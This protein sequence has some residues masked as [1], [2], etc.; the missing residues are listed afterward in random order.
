MPIGI[1]KSYNE[2]EKFGY[3]QIS[4]HDDIFFHHANLENAVQ[5]GDEVEFDITEGTHSKQAVYI[6]KK[7]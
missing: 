3:I 6:H 4:N 2:E 7:A 1:V 5:V